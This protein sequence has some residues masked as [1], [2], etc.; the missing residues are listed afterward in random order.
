ME[1]KKNIVDFRGPRRKTS[2]LNK[3]EKFTLFCN[4]RMPKL[5][6]IMNSIKNLANS[7]YYSYTS[8]EKKRIMKDYK[9]AYKAMNSAWEK[10]GKKQRA[11]YNKKL[12]LENK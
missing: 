2:R 1:N 7:N 6:A 9:E 8:D 10:A 5:L 11:S 3:R 12:Y 4:I